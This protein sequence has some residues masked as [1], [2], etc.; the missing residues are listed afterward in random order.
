MVHTKTASER[1]DHDYMYV[2]DWNKSAL[3]NIC[4]KKHPAKIHEEAGDL[5]WAL[6]KYIQNPGYC[7][8]EPPKSEYTGLKKINPG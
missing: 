6:P 2:G 1:A 8:E 7:F 5:H 4:D 3:I